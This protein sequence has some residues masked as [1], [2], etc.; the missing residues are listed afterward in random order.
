MIRKNAPFPKVILLLFLGVFAIN[1][2]LVSPVHA[3]QASAPQLQ[4]LTGAKAYLRLAPDDLYEQPQVNSPEF[5]TL[6]QPEQDE[7]LLNEFFTKKYSPLTK[8]IQVNTGWF[9][10]SS[11]AAANGYI[12]NKFYPNLIN[13]ANPTAIAISMTFSLYG[14]LLAMPFGFE[15]YNS[16]ADRYW[17]R[18]DDP[19]LHHEIDYI[20]KRRFLPV[21]LQ[22]S[23]ET[24]FKATRVD[25]ARIGRVEDYVGT[26]L[27]LP[28]ESLR[29]EFDLNLI[30]KLFDGY[31]TELR[32]QVES[33]VFQQV[34]LQ[35]A[36]S[37]GLREQS[38]RAGK[39]VAGYLIGP[40]GTGKSRYAELIARSLGLPFA[41]VSLEGASLDDLLG[42]S[43]DSDFPTPGKIAKA[44]AN[45]K[46]NGKGA[47]NLVLFIDEADRVINNQHPY[48]QDILPFMLKLLDPEAK[49]FFNPYFNAEI[50]ISNLTIILAGNFTIQEE[51]LKKRLFVINFPGFTLEY[52]KRIIWEST[53]PN[54]LTSF[55]Q[56]GKYSLSLADLTAEDK[57]RIQSLIQ[58]DKDPGF[59]TIES[60]LLHYFS[61]IARRKYFEP[62]AT[63][64]EH[65]MNLILESNQ[66]LE[67]QKALRA[68]KASQS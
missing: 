60:V 32:K 27:N 17:N 56:N 45:A 30:N 43:V 7:L 63:E 10:L 6:T 24:Q 66:D 61:F 3:Q 54:L 67:V 58:Q 28:L 15:I 51:A 12:L 4:G 65:I 33:F 22:K 23:I 2:T 42:R 59:R 62:K 9:T 50:D 46:I 21:G 68:K 14:S 26:A 39:R 57:E 16:I 48:S 47:K 55:S 1:S 52:R 41:K 40:P 29:T 5:A 25:E 49:S 8:Q 44:I 34:L 38:V 13:P 11:I 31:P 18:I 19:L 64:P 36:S 35:D 53:I 37:Y 20:R